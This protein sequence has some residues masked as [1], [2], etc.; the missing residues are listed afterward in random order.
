MKKVLFVML[1]LIILSSQAIASSNIY[2]FTPLMGST[3]KITYQV[4]YNNYSDTISFNNVATLNNG[5]AA[6]NGHNQSGQTITVLYTD[7]S[8]FFFQKGNAYT[9]MF[10]VSNIS[11]S[12]QFKL[13][14]ASATGFFQY[15]NNS[16]G[17]LS[18]QYELSCSRLSGPVGNVTGDINQCKIIAKSLSIDKETI[19]RA[20]ETATF[21][22][23]VISDCQAPSVYYYYSYC[24]NYGS[25]N[26]D[27]GFWSPLSNGF[28]T[29]ESCSIALNQ[30]GNYVIVAWVSPTPSTPDTIQMIGC[31]LTVDP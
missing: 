15:K 22:T 6:L 27:P 11:Y 16:T 9:V 1:I 3:W 26:Y 2:D 20:G 29:S 14:G 4:G 30:A 28:T 8:V 12:Y 25:S 10:D 18:R 19:P 23:K 21:T 5:V 31:T 17:E 24:P 13:D 7:A